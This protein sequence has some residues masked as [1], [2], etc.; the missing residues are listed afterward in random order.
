MAGVK[1]AQNTWT[2][3]FFALYLHTRYIYIYTYIMIYIY[4]P[5]FIHLTAIPCTWLSVSWNHG[6]K[7]SREF[8]TCARQIRFP[9]LKSFDLGQSSG[10]KGVFKGENTDRRVIRFISWLVLASLDL[11]FAQREHRMKG[12]RLSNI[13]NAVKNS[14]ECPILILSV[15][16]SST[17]IIWKKSIMF[18]WDG[19]GKS[20]II[21]LAAWWS[22]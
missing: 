2:P 9:N 15:F 4:I 6:V 16:T 13:A 17:S 19:G 14:I 21:I 7:G 5:V 1:M 20:I 8:V 10:P 18:H 3:V 12:N 22:A 11:A